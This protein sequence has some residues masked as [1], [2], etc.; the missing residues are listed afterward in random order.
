MRGND[1]LA[2][3]NCYEEIPLK[4]LASLFDTQMHYLLYMRYLWLQHV[5]AVQAP[6]RPE[7]R[8]RRFHFNMYWEQECKLIGQSGRC[9]S[10]LSRF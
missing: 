6:S 10:F 1:Q 2:A 5:D 4:F 7:R 8:G 9:F 3:A